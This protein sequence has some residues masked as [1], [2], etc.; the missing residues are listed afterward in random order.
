[1]RNRNRRAWS[2]DETREDTGTSS[3]EGKREPEN[4]LKKENEFFNGKAGQEVSFATNI[5]VCVPF[6]ALLSNTI[7]I[8]EY[9]LQS[10]SSDAG[11]N[12]STQLFLKHPLSFFSFPFSFRCF[13]CQTDIVSQ[14]HFFQLQVPA[15]FWRKKARSLD[16][17]SL[18]SNAIQ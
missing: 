6:K 17:S 7:W 3:S 13:A 18:L 4:F 16:L 12:C 14:K 1:M 2:V 15:T 5:G 11:Q 10:N 8:V 9:G